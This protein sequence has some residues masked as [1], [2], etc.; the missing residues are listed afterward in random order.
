M[1]H[2]ITA[3]NACIA[4]AAAFVGAGV[5]GFIPNPIVAP[6]GW[7]AVNTMHNLVHV[8]TG[9]AFLLGAFAWG[10]PRLTLRVVGVLYVAV[11]VLGF[12]TTGDMLLGLIHIN[13]A[14]RWLH[15]GLAAA[16]LGAGIAVP[17]A[18]P[19][20]SEAAPAA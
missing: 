20:S 17:E 6:D 11:S 12:L 5:L 15:V 13:E 9:V 14:D 18:K 7:F 2:L 1:S 19:S 3:K 4:F 16:I 10:K 8:I